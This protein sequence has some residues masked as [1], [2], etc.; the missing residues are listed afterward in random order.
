MTVTPDS[1]L[2]IRS[3][4][5]LVDAIVDAVRER[6]LRGELEPGLKIRQQEL[7]E[8]LGVSRT[9]LREAFQRLEADGWVQLRARRGAEVRMLTVAEAQDIF[10]MRVVL[11]TAAARLNAVSHPAAD[12]PRA[13]A[14]LDAP[15]VAPDDANTA[16]HELVYG[17]DTPQVPRELAAVLRGYWARA[18]RYRLVYWRRPA[19]ATR[20]RA[21]HGKI[22]EAWARRDAGATER[23][24]AEHIL[25]ALVEI[26]ARIDAD[27]EPSEAVRALARR[28]DLDLMTTPSSEDR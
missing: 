5:T 8:V 14:L 24:V 9:P 3:Q 23:A 27:H 19:S 10:T 20:S 28:Y 25:T 21:A 7:A 13:H 12:E 4:T 22:Y 17:L 6:I 11:E 15:D 16:F 18:L 26:T 1:G 2:G